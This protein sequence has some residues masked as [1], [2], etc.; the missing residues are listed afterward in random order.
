MGVFHGVP[1][2]DP[3][4][5][6]LLRS[7]GASI[8]LLPDKPNTGMGALGLELRRSGN[9]AAVGLEMALRD[10]AMSDLAHEVDAAFT[11]GLYPCIIVGSS[12]GSVESDAARLLILRQARGY[13]REGWAMPRTAGW[14]ADCIAPHEALAELD[15]AGKFANG[16]RRADGSVLYFL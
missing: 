13:R 8:L 1:P 10:D 12:S 16:G 2:R 6:R 11:A 5:L 7:S 14:S 4:Q 15:D 3:M 9:F